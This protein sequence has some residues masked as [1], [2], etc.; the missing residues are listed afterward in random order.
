MRFSVLA[1]GISLLLM[2]CNLSLKP[3]VSPTPS[4]PPTPSPIPTPTI[5]PGWEQVA[6]GMT[7]RTYRTNNLLTQFRTV[8]ID[9]THYRFEAHYRAREPLTL[10]QWQAALPDADL[11][12]NA[13]F[14]TPEYTVLGLL[15]SNGTIFGQAYTDR[16]GTFAVQNGA[17]RVYS[18][19]AEP[20]R[21]QALEQAVQAFPMLVQDGRATYTR[22]GAPSRRTVI[23]QDELGRIIIMV[24]P[25]LGPSLADLSAYLVTTDIGFVN[26][27][28]L[29]GGRST[30]L[31]VEPADYTLAS[32][33]PVPAVLA[34]YAR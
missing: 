8:R 33:D 3:A 23:G 2:G 15:V 26:A 28:N 32:V 14:F 10:A 18:N 9:P 7:M 21:G 12:V 34:I 17:V 30:M 6:T 1:I 24:T 4:P 29:D 16:G 19:R 27:F 31:W 22:S 5:E 13:N 20:Y 25:T 11:I